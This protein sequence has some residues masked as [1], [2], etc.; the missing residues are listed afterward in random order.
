[1]ACG[2][3]NIARFLLET[4][5][6]ESTKAM[7]T[8]K[9]TCLIRVYIAEGFD[10]AQRDIGSASDPYLVLQCGKKIFNDKDNY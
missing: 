6:E 10:F 3:L 2:H 1:M 8:S 4:K 7:L 5:Y 9:T